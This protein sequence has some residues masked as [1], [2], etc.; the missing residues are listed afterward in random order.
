MESL[1]SKAMKDKM[2]EMRRFSK[3]KRAAVVPPA[4]IGEER[5]GGYIYDSSLDNALKVAS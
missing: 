3:H 1:Q 4:V 5:G 2:M